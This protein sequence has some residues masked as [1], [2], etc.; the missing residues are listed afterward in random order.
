MRIERNEI[1]VRIA[2]EY[3]PACR[4]KRAAVGSAEILKAPFLCASER[5]KGFKSASWS[6][7]GIGKIGTADKVVSFAILLRGSG[8]DV[9]LG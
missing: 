7:H 4:G 1:A 6:F 5:I 8:K 9:A 3:H 2:G